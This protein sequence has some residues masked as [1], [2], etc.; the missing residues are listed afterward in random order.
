MFFQHQCFWSQKTMLK[1]TKFWSKRGGCNKAVFMNLCFVKCEKLSFFGPFF[2][3]FW[4]M[5]KNT[6]KF[7][8]QHMLKNRKITIFSKL[9]TGPS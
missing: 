3:Q 7:V 8:F 5:F 9:L 2:G 1:N 4:L 6:I